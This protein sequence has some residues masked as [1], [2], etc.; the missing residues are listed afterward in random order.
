MSDHQDLAGQVAIVTGAAAGIGLACATELAGRGASVALWDRDGDGVAAAAERIGAPASGF[1]V[2]VT[3]RDGVGGAVDATVEQFGRIDILVSN[4][5]YGRLGA[6]IDIEP[7]VWQRHLAVNLGGSFHVAQL[8][9][10]AMIRCGNGGAMVFT[11]STASLFPCDHLSAYAVCKAGIAML[12]RSLSSELG[13]HGI[14]VNTVMPGVIESSM[15]TSMLEEDLSR[16]LTVSETP[17]GRIGEP[18]D[19]AEVVAF[20]ASPASRYVTGASI[21][22]DG[23]QTT[24]GYPRWRSADGSLGHQ[25]TWENH[26]ARTRRFGAT[27]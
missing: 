5:G 7:E 8:V 13:P 25:A 16:T 20:L 18:A 4:A 21:L 17:L 11:G 2:D 27:P 19:V 12:A 3:D 23:G 22:V 26:A 9:A 15:T 10:R 14:R 24:H 6:F 1:H